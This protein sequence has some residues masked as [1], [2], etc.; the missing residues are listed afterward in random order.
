MDMLARPANRIV[1]RF[2]YGT[3]AYWTLNAALALAE[4]RWH[5]LYR[6][7]L[8]DISQFKVI[9]AALYHVARTGVAGH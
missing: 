3:A 2:F 7:T 9:G 6:L 8:W 1:S 5:L 4:V